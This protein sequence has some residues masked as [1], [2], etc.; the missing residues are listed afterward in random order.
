[1]ARRWWS[2]VALSTAVLAVGIDLTV[3]NVALPNLAT[4]L[5]AST[6][7]L[8]WFVDAYSLVVAALLVPA[9]LLADRF[10]RRRL[11]MAAI[12]VFALGSV[13]CAYAGSPAA[14]VAGRAVLG[15]G[16]AVILTVSVSLLP[17]L[18]PDDHERQKATAAV[19]GCTMLGYPLGPVIG[20][21]L[22]GHFWWGSIFLVNLP[23]AALALLAVLAVMPESRRARPP[24]PDTPGVIG[25]TL[26]LSGL[27]LVGVT[28]GVIE[29]G[30]E[31]WGSPG[32]LAPLA[33]GLAALAAFAA[34]ER[35]RPRH[36]AEPLIDLGLFS[37]GPF[38]WGTVLATLVSFALFGLLFA[39]PQYFEGVTGLTA[40]ASGVRLLPFIGGFVL[41]A[42]VVTA[43]QRDGEPH[44]PA[45]AGPRVPAN[46]VAS[47]GFAVMA[48]GLLLGATTTLD[49]APGWAATWFVVCGLGLGSA[50]P[51]SMNVALGALGTE[52]TGAGS[53]LIMACRQVGATVGVA[54]LGTVLNSGY[55]H[56]V[57]V[58]GL[59]PGAAGVAR[60]GLGNGLV[61]A[62][63]LGDGPLARSAR[64]A[65]VLSLDEMLRVCAGTALVATV[66]ALAFLSRRRSAR[67]SPATVRPEPVVAG[68]L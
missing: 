39:M 16:A 68:D 62:Q 42:I 43:L 20:G 50:L 33:G 1:V 19:M 28:Y 40:L 12:A 37:S 2:L 34:W 7:Q 38:A 46:I 45:G 8:Q 25:A 4:S 13:A 9:G 10:G 5:H 61:V 29:A 41:G 44:T 49:S 55:R 48:A 52:R 3:L 63:R 32:A 30:Q 47:A 15:I 18:F 27:G 35:R 67:T 6:S 24:R 26:G 11:L 53:G 21:W 60:Q 14:L 54:V 65:F 56:H 66:L 22:L 59:P 51:A 64:S 57:A 36:H 31:G 23:V 17:V 58:T